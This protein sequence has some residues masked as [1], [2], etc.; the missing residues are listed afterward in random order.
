VRRP[1]LTVFGITVN[2]LSLSF[3]PAYAPRTMTGRCSYRYDASHVLL[4][5]VR[6][7]KNEHAAHGSTNCCSDL[8]Y[9]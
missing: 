9:P 5:K 4:A 6:K 8:F 2:A 3:A 1:D 7:L